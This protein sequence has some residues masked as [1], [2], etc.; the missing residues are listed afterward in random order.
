MADSIQELEALMRIADQNPA[1]I[2]SV[3]ARK[4]AAQPSKLAELEQIVAQ[5]EPIPEGTGF[6][7]VAEPALAMGANLI[8]TPVIGWMG[9]VAAK[10]YGPQFAAKMIEDLMEDVSS[11]TQPETAQG[12]KSMEKISKAVE[13]GEKI[14][15]QPAAG[16]QM[17]YELASG[18]G[19]DEAAKQGEELVEKGIGNFYGDMTLDTFGNPEAATAVRM[20]P[21]SV[22]ALLS[23]KA[24]S[25]VKKKAVPI[26]QDVGAKVS[27][28]VN[29]L[30]KN[31]LN[32]PE[33][34]FIDEAG[35]ITTEGME[36]I[37]QLSEAGADLSKI[38]AEVAKQLQGLEI[39]TP[40]EA[41]RFNLFKKYNITPV[42]SQI[43]QKGE[44][45]II[46][47]ELAKGTNPVSEIIASQDAALEAAARAGLEAIG[48]TTATA[49]QTN[50][51]L[52]Q[53]LDNVVGAS[54]RAT[55]EAYRLAREVA[56][57]EK[58]VRLDNLMDE[59]KK[60]VGHERATGGLISSIR[61]DLE[62][63]GIIASGDKK[64]QN[65]GRIDPVQAEDVRIM[66]NNNYNSTTD[67]GRMII[68]DLKAALDLDVEDAVGMDVFANARKA[69]IEQERLIRKQRRDARDKT[70]STLLED[71]LNNKI[72]ER[73]IVDRIL[74][75][76]D[77]EFEKIF[78]FYNLESGPQG[79]QAWQNLK[80]QVFMD[81]IEA[82]MASRGKTEGGGHVFKGNVFDNQFNHLRDPSKKYEI[83]F[84]ESERQLIADIAE[85]DWLRN[86]KSGTYTGKGPTAQAVSEIVSELQGSADDVSEIKKAV[87]QLLNGVTAGASGKIPYLNAQGL[88]KAAK[89]KAEKKA[90]IAEAREAER[91][92]NIT[93]DTE[94]AAK[95]LEKQ[96]R[97]E[98]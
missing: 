97:D 63:K 36:H 8:S 77:D 59:L 48:G 29:N 9:L 80:A 57:D 49:A 53:V 86:P 96:R 83:L 60:N 89:R 93:A 62:N 71:I 18:E 61:T 70:K 95:I 84:N 92:V 13:L 44:D 73:K 90:K 88:V 14:I 31:I 19:V 43:T 40:D 17:L 21:D 55:T 87:L 38:D 56:G 4:P 7:A 23:I 78:E 24:P 64:F 10:K 50:A 33:I 22:A 66:L 1:Q 74:S 47:Q 68:R 28:G 42:R 72:E 32:E 34:D 5:P 39:L 69:K 27:I 52:F 46:S 35:L 85:I 82:A 2:P 67:R 58:V 25:F 98:Q 6:D 12:Q 45:F 94:K 75:A 11:L 91:Q 16:L 37:K 51:N 79:I 30:V 41:A 26:A 81:A 15:R 54:E 20:I 76:R 65:L 3:A